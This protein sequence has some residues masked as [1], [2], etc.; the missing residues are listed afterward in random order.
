M[1]IAIHQMSFLPWQ[2]YYAKM[3]ESDIFIES[4]EFQFSPNEMYHRT[5]KGDGADY[6]T[7][8]IIKEKDQ[9]IQDV[10]LRKD[11]LIKFRD[12]FKNYLF[13][14]KKHPELKHWKRIYD[15]FEISMIS[16]V[17]M[18][19]LS[20]FIN[21]FNSPVVQYLGLTN[22][23]DKAYLDNGLH[24]TEQLLHILKQMSEAGTYISGGGGRS[25]L[26]T[27]LLLN[28]GFSTNFQ[29]ITN[30]NLWHGSIVHLL[31]TKEKEEILE[32]LRRNFSYDN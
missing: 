22:R 1:R 14:Y 18:N 21:T 12:S 7:I 10:L 23:L 25:Y 3:L 17:N 13:S 16:C 26:D 2:G 6:L 20:G 30:P 29:S 19:T 5:F 9:R 4:S 32:E 24:K 31:F 15:L 28:D 8:P 27:E 11:D